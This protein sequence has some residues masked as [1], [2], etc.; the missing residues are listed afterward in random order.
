METQSVGTQGFSPSALAAQGAQ[1]SQTAKATVG[2]GTGVSR[3]DF[4]TRR[5]DQAEPV[6]DARQ[7]QEAVRQAQET[8][9]QV[10]DAR[11]DQL[12]TEREQETTR[13]ASSDRREREDNTYTASAAVARFG[14]G[15]QAS[16]SMVDLRA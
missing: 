1:A 4:Q 9:R 5:T 8:A 11:S 15:Q 16:G 10:G 6:Q 7:T 12:R 3:D 2:G 14:G 13:T